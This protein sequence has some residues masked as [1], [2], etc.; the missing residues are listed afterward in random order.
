MSAVIEHDSPWQHAPL[1]QV[2]GW[3]VEAV[4]FGT[5]PSFMHRRFFVSPVQT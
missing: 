1:Q 5:P 2:F 3:Q 4:Q